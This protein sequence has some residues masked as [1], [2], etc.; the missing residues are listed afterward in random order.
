MDE[1]KI[2]FKNGEIGYFKLEDDN[3]EK[4]FDFIGDAIRDSA[5][6]VLE[7]IDLVDDKRTIVNISEISTFGYSKISD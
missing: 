5:T 1:I 7:L 4:V 6:G 2:R 3:I